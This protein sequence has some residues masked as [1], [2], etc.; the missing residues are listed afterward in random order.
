MPEEAAMMSDDLQIQALDAATRAA[1]ARRVGRQLPLD[2]LEGHEGRIEHVEKPGRRS[3]GAVG[4][5]G[6]DRIAFDFLDL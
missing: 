5:E 2:L 1:R 4:A 3:E 6:E